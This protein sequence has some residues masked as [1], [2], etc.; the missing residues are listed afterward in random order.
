LLLADQSDNYRV[1]A[2]KARLDAATHII[3]TDQA[4]SVI[5]GFIALHPDDTHL[6]VASAVLLVQGKDRSG[7]ISALRPIAEDH[8]EDSY[9]H[10]VLAGLLGCDQSTWDE[11]WVHYKIALRHGALLTPGYRTAALYLAK[12]NEPQMIPEV[13]QGTGTVEKL[14]IRTRA[15]GFNAIFLIFAVLAVSAF[16]I[17]ASPFHSAVPIGLMAAATAWAGWSAFA[18]YVV[19]CWK[20]FSAWVVLAVLPW[21]FLLVVR[22]TSGWGWPIIVGLSVLVG[23][24][25]GPKTGKRGRSSQSTAKLAAGE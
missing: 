13:L 21:P 23:V 25:M 7:A 11:A 15:I 9:V 22:S 16:V 12:K 2:L 14:A 17:R 10:Q 5:E 6:K 4:R 20:C 24:A 3:S 8:P 18:N 19:G 1:L